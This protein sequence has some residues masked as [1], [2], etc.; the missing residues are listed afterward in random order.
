MAY[1][2]VE[3][4]ITRTF[5]DGKGFEVA[6]PPF[7]TKDGKEIV[8]RYTLWFAEPQSFVVGDQGH[9][10]G[11]LSTKIDSYTNKDGEQKQVVVVAIN[12]TKAKTVA[13]APAPKERDLD[14]E[15]KYG[16]MPF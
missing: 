12:N 4:T 16:S 1:I 9:F 5:F 8:S 11:T 3:G 14:D 15:A 6:E 2:A 7:I 10:S 13:T